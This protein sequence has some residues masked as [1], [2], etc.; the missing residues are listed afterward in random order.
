ML[1]FLLWIILIYLL[2]RI[3][4]RYLFPFL[5]KWY[6][7]RFQQ[8]FYEQNPHIRNNE[9]TSPDGKVH[10]KRPGRQKK[11]DKDIGEYINFE[12]VDE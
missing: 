9:K 5:V 10:I 1:N 3:A 11:N 4:V 8:R 12:E 6:L 7:K 2:F